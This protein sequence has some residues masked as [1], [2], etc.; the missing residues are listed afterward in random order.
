VLPVLLVLLVLLVLPVL[1]GL[2]WMILT[3][4]RLSRPRPKAK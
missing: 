1:L 2:R 3:N 4:S